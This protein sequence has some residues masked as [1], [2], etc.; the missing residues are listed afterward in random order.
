M[1]IVLSCHA[2]RSYS[3]S[4]RV[5]GIR[6]GLTLVE[7][8]ISFGVLVL[9]SSGIL[10]GIVLAAKVQQRSRLRAEAFNVAGFIADQLRYMGAESLHAG[11]MNSVPI[12]VRVPGSLTPKYDKDLNVDDPN[13]EFF[14]LSPKLEIATTGTTYAGVAAD[15]RSATDNYAQLWSAGGALGPKVNVF[16]TDLRTQPLVLLPGLRY[17]LTL[18]WVGGRTSSGAVKT[19]VVAMVTEN[20][21]FNKNGT[22]FTDYM[23]R[24]DVSFDPAQMP[25]NQPITATARAYMTPAVVVKPN[26]LFVK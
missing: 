17:Q 8:L 5:G 10:G 25:G 6:S 9:V 12:G 4:F 19:Y 20:R 21:R 7:V 16:W 22:P 11:A 23:I 13:S 2:P 14:A 26:V 1:S 3:R 15:I 24:V 18:P